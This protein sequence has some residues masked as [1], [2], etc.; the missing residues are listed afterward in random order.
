VESRWRASWRKKIKNNHESARIE[1]AEMSCKRRTPQQRRLLW[2][3][4][5]FVMRGDSADCGSSPLSHG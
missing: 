5:T 4:V 2:R 1:K 3:I